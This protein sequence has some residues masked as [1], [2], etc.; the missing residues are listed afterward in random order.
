[1]RTHNIA[2]AGF[3]FKRAIDQAESNDVE[4]NPQQFGKS[5]RD[6]LSTPFA[7][8]VRYVGSGGRAWSIGTLESIHSTICAD[9]AEM[10]EPPHALR[11]RYI[12]SDRGSF[13]I[14]RDQ[15]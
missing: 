3:V 1:M 11:G 4:Y 13:D 15:P 10:H 14:R 2:I 5:T 12:E 8:A 6:P 7:D 9:R